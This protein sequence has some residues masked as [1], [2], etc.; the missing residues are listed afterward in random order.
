MA[1]ERCSVCGGGKMV[2]ENKN[3]KVA[4]EKGMMHGDQITFE[5]EGDSFINSLP[6]DIQF[7][8][9][10]RPHSQFTRDKDDLY[11]K[12]PISFKEALFGFSKS[13]RHLDNRYV[14]ISKTEPSQPNSFVVLK[15]EGMPKRNSPLESGDLY[16]ELIIELPKTLKEEQKKIV[17]EILD[18][19]ISK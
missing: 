1:H 15:G 7:D 4:I 18:Y 9:H 3:F 8:I 16:L 10:I 19:A 5:G 6:G 12:L 13:V 11:V 17:R 2:T 14:E